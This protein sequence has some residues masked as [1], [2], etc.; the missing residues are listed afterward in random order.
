MLCLIDAIENDV[1]NGNLGVLPEAGLDTLSNQERFQILAGIPKARQKDFI[2]DY[3]E[4]I[5]QTELSIKAEFKGYTIL[6]AAVAND[7]D[8]I[9]A[10]LLAN[11]A[12]ITYIDANKDS[13]LHTATKHSKDITIFEMLCDCIDDVDISRM[14][15][16]R[17]ATYYT[18]MDYLEGRDDEISVAKALL[19]KIKGSQSDKFDAIFQNS[20]HAINAISRIFD[21]CNERTCNQLIAYIKENQTNGSKV[22][23]ECILCNSDKFSADRVNNA[24]LSLVLNDTLDIDIDHI[25]KTSMEEV[26]K[27]LV[28]SRDIRLN[29]S[30]LVRC[31]NN[32]SIKKLIDAYGGNNATRGL[33]RELN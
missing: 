9:T 23:N 1:K 25:A 10:W 17:T 31:N 8:L 30:S 6:H 3:S 4:I 14:V 11:G 2:R 24:L 16:S 19:L 28:Q 22:I 33:I 27:T 32:Q 26:I 18:A 15:K 12:L 21:K 13:V 29:M 7:L 5:K 20:P